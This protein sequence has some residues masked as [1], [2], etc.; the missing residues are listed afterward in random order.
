MTVLTELLPYSVEMV[1]HQQLTFVAC[2]RPWVGGKEALSS[3]ACPESVSR[4]L[5][6]SRTRRL[7]L[8][9]S[10]KDVL[11]TALAV[12]VWTVVRVQNKE[13]CCLHLVLMKRMAVQASV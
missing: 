13:A 3:A 2:P 7:P 10:V 9:T 6:L 11:H 5:D 1:S 8:R 4:Y 12:V